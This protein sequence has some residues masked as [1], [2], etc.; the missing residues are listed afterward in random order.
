MCGIAGIHRRGTAPV[1]R[2]GKLADGLLL[3]ISHRGSD[4]TGFLAMK[5]DGSVQTQKFAYGIE[6]GL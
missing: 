5:D 4:A 2:L 3:G 1:P 6:W